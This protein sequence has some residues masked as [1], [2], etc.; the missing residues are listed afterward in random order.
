MTWTEFEAMGGAIRGWQRGDGDTLALVLHGGPGMTDYTEDLADEVAAG[1]GAGS[2]IVRYQQ[3]GLSP[4]TLAGP[5]TV[6]QAV[7]DLIAVLDHLGAA[8]GLL[9]GHSWG[10]HLAMH[11][12]CAHP[13]RVSG[14]VLIDSLG[15][16]G[17]GGEGTM[18]AVISD[19]IG[20][21]AQRRYDE[22]GESENR[23]DEDEVAM[24]AIAW[25]GYFSDPAAA[26]PMPPLRLS[27]A[28]FGE[29]AADAMRLLEEGVLERAIPSLSIP[30]IHMIGNASPIDPAANLA[31]AALF[32]DSIVQAFDDTGHFI[33]IERPGSVEAAVRSLP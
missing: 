7:D 3:R 23:S 25:P 22:L 15:A 19:R 28:V 30:S 11:A 20:A 6:A 24:L 14:L 16:I 26:A 21:D 4:S 8:D 17:D 13:E 18:E 31:T 32:R 10:G 2:R 1:M 29:L 27:A 5:F 12:A 33:W 9:V